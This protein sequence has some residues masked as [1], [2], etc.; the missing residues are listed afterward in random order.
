MALPKPAPASMVDTCTSNKKDDE[1]DEDE[2]EEVGFFLVNSLLKS[3]VKMKFMDLKIYLRIA[4]VFIYIHNSHHHHH[5]HNNNNNY[6]YYYK[7]DFQYIIIR[8]YVNNIL[9]VFRIS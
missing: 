7:I 8:D 9:Q 5:N 2:Q 6:Y 3:F 1:N 4:Y